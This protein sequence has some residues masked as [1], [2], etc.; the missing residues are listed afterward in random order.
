VMEGN[1][2][3][4]RIAAWIADRL[5]TECFQHSPTVYVDRVTVQESEGNVAIWER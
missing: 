3:A 1:P 4:E 2:T 5:H